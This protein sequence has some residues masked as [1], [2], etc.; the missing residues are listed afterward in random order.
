MHLYE[1]AK[2]SQIHRDRKQLQEGGK[3]WKLVFNGFG[4]SVGEDKKNSGESTVVMVI[5][6]EC[7]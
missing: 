2:K 5:Q 4:V 6:C 3:M 7:T 1:G